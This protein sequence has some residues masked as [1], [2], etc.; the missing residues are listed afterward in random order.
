MN[1]VSIPSSSDVSDIVERY[2]YVA[3]TSNNSPSRDPIRSRI[4]N[5][6]S[7]G[8]SAL[9]SVLG[10]ISRKYG[11]V[12]PVAILAQRLSNEEMRSPSAIADAINTELRR[13]LTWRESMPTMQSHHTEPK[14]HTTS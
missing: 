5:N 1:G 6:V 11:L 13:I 14:N 2:F 8:I 12:V 9:V 3:Q 4:A 10:E 7:N